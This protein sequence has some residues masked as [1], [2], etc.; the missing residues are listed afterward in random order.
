MEGQNNEVLAVAEVEK[1]EGW[2]HLRVLFCI[3]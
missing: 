2:I 1:G 3:S